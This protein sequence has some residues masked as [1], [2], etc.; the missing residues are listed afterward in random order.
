MPQDS[1]YY[2]DPQDESQDPS[3]GAPDSSGVRAGSD[4]E[5]ASEDAQEPSEDDSETFLTPKSAF[6]GD[7]EP[8]TKMQFEA[9]KIY[10]DEIEWKPISASDK[11]DKTSKKP[12][13]SAD[14]EIDSMASA[15][16]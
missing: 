10:D 3:N 11:P 9:V 8:G 12:A 4:T 6:S 7:I 16:A 1:G 13:M 5:N 15:G 2:G 14:D